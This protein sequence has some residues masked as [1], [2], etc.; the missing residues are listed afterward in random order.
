MLFWEEV[1]VGNVP[2]RVAFPRLFSISEQKGNIIADMGSFIDG[3]WEWAFTWRRVFF[4]WEEEL[5][6]AL[7]G[8]LKGVRNSMR[9]ISGS[10]HLL[11]MVSSRLRLLMVLHRLDF[12]ATLSWSR[13][14]ARHLVVSEKV[15]HLQRCVPFPG[16][17]CWGELLP[18]QTSFGGV[19]FW[20]LWM[21]VVFSV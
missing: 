18:G 9:R 11:R 2:L 6:V 16:R 1:W 19:S 20:T 5:E 4:S 21:H 14:Y 7:R 15:M 13:P 3:R 17:Y 10:G 12:S 8:A